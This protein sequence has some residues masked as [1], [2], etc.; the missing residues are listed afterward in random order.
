MFDV[1]LFFEFIISN[2]GQDRRGTFVE[3]IMGSLIALLLIT[4]IIKIRH[5]LPSEI[6]NK[7]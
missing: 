2:D 4:R 7:R 1:G 3:A 5:P 6:I